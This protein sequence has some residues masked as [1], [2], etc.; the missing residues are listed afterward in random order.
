MRKTRATNSPLT[1]PHKASRGTKRLRGWTIVI[2]TVRHIGN[3]A[4]DTGERRLP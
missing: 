2:G 4:T 3:S 1:M